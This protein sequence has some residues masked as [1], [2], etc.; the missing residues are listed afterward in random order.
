MNIGLGFFSLNKVYD[1]VRPDYDFES[2][3]DF[4]DFGLAGNRRLYVFL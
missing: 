4:L 2:A 3:Y 1:R